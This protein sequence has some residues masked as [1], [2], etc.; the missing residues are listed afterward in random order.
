MAAALVPLPRRRRPAA[1]LLAA[2][3]ALFAAAGVLLTAAVLNAGQA[4]LNATA[5]PQ[6][7]CSQLLGVKKVALMF[8]TTRRLAHE[9]LWRLWLWDAAN[10]LPLQA[11]PALQDGLCG[12]D[13]TAA[14]A[15]WQRLRGDCS[16]VPPLV[17]TAGQG[18]TELP[19]Q[20]LFTVYAHAPPDYQGLEYQPLLAGRVIPTRFKTWWGD[21]S[22][23]DAEKALL[24]EA[25]KDPLNEK[26]ALISDSD[27]PLYD[28]LTFY[29]QLMHEPRSRVRACAN[30]WMNRDRWRD[31][32]ST[33]TMNGSHWRKS[34]Q[35]FGLTRRHAEIVLNDQEAERSFREHCGGWYAHLNQWK[36]C[37]A[38]E[39]YV[40]TLL[41][42]L[43][44]EDET[45]CRGWGLAY[46]DWSDN[47]I[48][49]KSFKPR[50]VTPELL[51]K[52]RWNCE[53]MTSAVEDSRHMFLPLEPLLAASSAQQACQA[54]QA[55]MPPAGARSNGSDNGG[56]DSLLP[57]GSRRY[58]HPLDGACPLTARKL[59]AFTALRV[60]QL[61]VASC[62]N[63]AA[64]FV[65][66]RAALVFKTE[67]DPSVVLLRGTACTPDVLRQVLAPPLSAG[68][69]TGLAAAAGAAGR[70]LLCTANRYSGG[71]AAQW[72]PEGLD[73][74][75][76]CDL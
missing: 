34:N 3:V 19:P 76:L 51:K 22:I 24:R 47:W 13:A 64:D 57:L 39:H 45:Y 31:E 2:A 7:A 46:T 41:A 68:T 58:A 4:A 62:P 18:P 37:I 1:R 53:N 49:P 43:G 15:F 40:P 23:L 52:M 72:L 26:F 59:P 12:S 33:E 61:A 66:S 17:D 55:P 54:L 38:D 30:G 11:L 75:E 69:G 65:E 74:G 67:R 10:L 16:V 25:L 28:P 21:I 29:Q 9:K 14:D 60:R 42:S 44:L 27:V 6:G 36:E 32:M 50:D 56:S 63:G 35:F 71:A 73:W 5:A 20:H 8:L 48:H 70:R